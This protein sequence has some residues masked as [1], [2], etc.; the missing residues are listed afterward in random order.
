MIIRWPAVIVARMP[1]L[2]IKE[3]ILIQIPESAQ[4]KP[5]NTKSYLITLT[6]FDFKRVIIREYIR[7]YIKYQCYAALLADALSMKIVKHF[8]ISS[9]AATSMRL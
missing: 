9:N 7:N 8:E 4:D 1:I 2:I 5:L 3:K 6:S